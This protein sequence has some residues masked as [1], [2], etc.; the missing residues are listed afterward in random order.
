[1]EFFLYF[2]GFLFLFLGAFAISAL[3]VAYG[4]QYGAIAW[5]IYA[6]FI[7]SI[8][9]VAILRIKERMPN[10]SGEGWHVKKKEHGVEE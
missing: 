4:T 10:S 6:T 3:T 5:G 7:G 8:V 2:V 9:G 1:M